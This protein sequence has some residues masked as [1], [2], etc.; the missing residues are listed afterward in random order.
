MAPADYW[1]ASGLLPE[2]RV[3]HYCRDLTIVSNQLQQLLSAQTLRA[4]KDRG[5]P[6]F[7]GRE[8]AEAHDSS[9]K[10]GIGTWAEAE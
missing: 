9:F 6:L 7:A 1:K 2:E 5:E 4:N 10:S 8:T 3:A